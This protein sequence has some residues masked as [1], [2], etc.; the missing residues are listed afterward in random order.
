[1]TKKSKD[2]LDTIIDAFTGKPKRRKKTTTRKN[3]TTIHTKIVEKQVVVKHCVKCGQTIPEKAQF[4]EKCGEKQSTAKKFK[5]CENCDRDIAQGAVY[6]EF[7]GVK[8][9]S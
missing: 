3:T 7:C 1:M 6:C 8:Q 9:S 2:P 5:K 4:C